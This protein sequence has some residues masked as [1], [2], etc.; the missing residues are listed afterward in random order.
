MLW[1]ISCM[2]FKRAKEFVLCLILEDPPSSMACRICS[3]VATFLCYVLFIMTLPLS[4]YFTLKV[5]Q[6]C[7]TT[8]QIISS[9]II[10]QDMLLSL[11]DCPDK[12]SSEFLE[13]S[14]CYINRC[15]SKLPTGI[16]K[17]G[18]M[19]DEEFCMQVAV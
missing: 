3:S 17:E 6:K 13:T 10:P 8:G 7:S 14:V 12:L 19:H 1:Q 2:K 4:M 15:Y 18:R 5:T 11:T 9:N 16:T